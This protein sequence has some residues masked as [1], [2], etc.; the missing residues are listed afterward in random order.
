MRTTTVCLIIYLF[1][2]SNLFSQNPCNT[3]TSVQDSFIIHK[4]ETIKIG[5]FEIGDPDY[6]QKISSLSKRLES[7]TSNMLMY[8]AI[9]GGGN[10]AAP[11]PYQQ[12]YDSDQKLLADYQNR[13]NNRN[14]ERLNAFLTLYRVS[15]NRDIQ[16]SSYFVTIS[17]DHSKSTLFDRYVGFF[18]KEDTVKLYT[19]RGYIPCITSTISEKN[20]VVELLFSLNSNDIKFLQENRLE[21]ISIQSAKSLLHSRIDKNAYSA[22]KHHII[23]ILK[24]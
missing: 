7:L 2:L 17:F 24:E 12:M 8:S 1:C 13:Q 15:T 14:Y 20:G 16:E 18:N 9:A 5:T 10:E 3:T 11:N 22:L 23:C 19:P 21:D 6:S 4:S